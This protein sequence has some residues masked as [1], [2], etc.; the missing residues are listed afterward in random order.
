MVINNVDKCTGC[1]VCAAVCKKNCI[2]VKLNSE[3]FYRPYL[4][5]A[6][7]CLDCGICDLVCPRNAQV[8][9]GSPLSLVAANTTAEKV[10][11]TTSSG[12]VCYELAKWGLET[13]RK[14]CACTYDYKDHLA[15]HSV[16][17]CVEELEGTKGSKYMQSYTPDSFR[18]V[19]NGEK[20][21]VF[22]TP[23]QIAAMDR[24]AKLRKVRENLILVDFFCH[25]T[26]T[27]NLWKKYINEHDARRVAKIDFRSKEFGWHSW[28]FRFYYSDGT[29][30]SDPKRNMFYKFF[31]SNLCLN[32]ACYDCGF[33]AFH[34]LADIR[35]G[36]FWGKKYAQDVAGISSCAVMTPQGAQAMAELESC[37][38]ITPA[39][40]AD[41]LEVQMVKSPVKLQREYVRTM[42]ALKGKRSLRNIYDTT[43]LPLRIKGLWQMLTRR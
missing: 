18:Q 34:S 29:S 5:D 6:A 33:K 14:V 25:G 21:I 41:V 17:E 2:S 43:L 19:L 11:R 22:G 20:W 10:L 38:R 39:E 15:V 23:C 3:G 42:R 31:F 12:G 35:V 36:D 24:A 4:T 40:E 8:E 37:C 9:A 28:S 30:S 32:D 13:G 26:P 16:I 27:M 7:A 1:G